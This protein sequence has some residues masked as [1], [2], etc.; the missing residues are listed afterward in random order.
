MFLHIGSNE[1]IYTKDIIG[2]FDIENATLSGITKDFLKKRQGSLA[3]INIS[4]DIPKSFVLTFDGTESK[5]YLSGSSAETL[6]KRIKND[7]QQ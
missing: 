7:G 5:A 2:I 3:L 6:M 1:S 4:N